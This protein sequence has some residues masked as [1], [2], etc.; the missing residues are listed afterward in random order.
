MNIVVLTTGGT[1]SCT[2]DS[3]GAL[4]PTVSGEQL[5]E[6]VQPLLEGA[7]I[8][9]TVREITRLDSSAMTFFDID[10]IVAAVHAALADP[11]V[12][13]VVVTHGTDSMEETAVAVDTFTNDDRP[14]IFTG[15]MRPFDDEDPDGVRN[16]FEAI[17][18]ATDPS[19]QGIGTLIVFSHAVIPA[20]GA[21]KWHTHDTLAFATNGPEEPQR[22]DPVSPVPLAD[23]R[24]DIVTAYPG[25]PRDIIDDA[26]AREVDGLVVEAMGEGNVGSQVA[27]GITEALAKDIPVVITTRVPRGEV[28]GNY[29]GAGGGA[30]LQALGAYGSTY[31][32]AGQARVL[33]AIAVA[34]GRHIATLL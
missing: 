3:S 6:A 11:D 4:I 23:L 19:A 21:M 8:E 27:A 17:L 15:A 28:A 16:L 30:S 20:R 31:F 5:M 18:I 2:R 29:G 32:R 26:V 25:A 1:I 22:A 9:V 34:S 7:D 13:G 24:V 33:L 10:E 14:V 12:D